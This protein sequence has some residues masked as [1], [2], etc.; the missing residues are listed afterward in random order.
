MNTASYDERFQETVIDSFTAGKFFNV[1]KSY[2]FQIQIFLA[3]CTCNSDGKY[4][5]SLNILK[6][7]LSALHKDSG[8]RRCLFDGRL[9]FDEWIRT[10]SLVLPGGKDSKAFKSKVIWKFLSISG[11]DFMRRSDW[12]VALKK[13]IF[14][15]FK[16]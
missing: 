6:C 14:I 10:K 16:I 13:I 7:F 9:P 2:H 12:K 4:N 5:L 3:L 8:G 1:E 11:M 15:V